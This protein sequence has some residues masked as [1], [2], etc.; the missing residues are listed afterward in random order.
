MIHLKRLPTLTAFTEVRS[1]KPKAPITRVP[2]LPPPIVA[3][4]LSTVTRA[5]REAHIKF[6]LL[7]MIYTLVF[8]QSLV[9][10]FEQDAGGI[11]AHF[12]LTRL[13]G[14]IVPSNNNGQLADSTTHDATHRSLNNFEDLYYLLLARVKAMHAE[15]RLRVNNGFMARTTILHSKGSS[16][17]EYFRSITRRFTVA[18]ALNQLS[19]FWCILNDPDLVKPLNTVVKMQHMNIQSHAPCKGKPEEE[20]WTCMNTEWKESDWKEIQGLK[21]IGSWSPGMI[22][23]HLESRFKRV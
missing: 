13:T 12:L 2:E 17:G 19:L 3:Q 16:D 1:K 14:E 8:H 15:L 22:A 18:D 10:F 4:D 5:F 7:E 11:T 23:C 20:R 9:H 6:V 21:F